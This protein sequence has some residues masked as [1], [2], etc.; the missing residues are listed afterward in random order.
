MPRLGGVLLL[1]AAA[2]AVAYGYLFP[3]ADQ[4]ADVD[5]VIRISAA[6]DRPQPGV[7]GIGAISSKPSAF[8]EV[9]SEDAARLSA[10]PSPKPASWSRV[11]PADQSIASPLRSADPADPETR[12]GLASD[13][14]RELRRVGCYG[15]EITGTWNAASRRAMAAFMDRANATLPFDHPDYVL[16]ALVQSHQD[17][18]CSADCPVGQIAENGRC[19]PRAVVAQT[20]KKMRRLDERRL[21]AAH[22]AGTVKSAVTAEPEKLPWL[23]DEKVVEAAPPATR[24][25]ASPV[26]L[27]G[28]MSVGAPIAEL[29]AE[30]PANASSQWKPLVIVPDAARAADAAPSS[31]VVAGLGQDSGWD[32]LSTGANAVPLPLAEPYGSAAKRTPRRGYSGER[33]RRKYAARSGRRGEP[34]RGTARYNLMLSLGGIY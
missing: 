20:Q 18:A 11:V 14:Q 27:P 3:A 17:V 21:A 33:P 34:R 9:I 29:P 31:T 2:V 1:T 23:Q 10:P 12:A 4:T 8:H 25:E 19:V 32:D 28:R 13:L 7:A 22:D 30:A 16:L 15:G 26:P 6:P 24:A 5:E